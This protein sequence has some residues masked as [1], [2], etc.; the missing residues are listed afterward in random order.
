MAPELKQALHEAVVRE[1]CPKYLEP[2][3]LIDWD[4]VLV[5]SYWDA[6]WSYSEYTA[7]GGDFTVSVSGELLATPEEGVSYAN[8]SWSA[9]YSPEDMAGLMERLMS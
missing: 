1:V 4:S 7:G 6:P 8:F 3:Y 5:S 2:P 9:T